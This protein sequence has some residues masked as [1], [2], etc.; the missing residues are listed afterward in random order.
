M[1]RMTTL[2][3][4]ATVT[5]CAAEAAFS[6]SPVG[7]GPRLSIVLDGGSPFSLS[8]PVRN[9]VLA[10][11]GSD[12]GLTCRVTGVAAAARYQA[13]R[14]NWYV[15]EGLRGG[16]GGDRVAQKRG[17][18]SF[19]LVLGGL[20]PEDSGTLKCTAEPERPYHSERDEDNAPEPPLE[21]TITLKVKCKEGASHHGTIIIILRWLCCSRSL[22]LFGNV[23][24]WRS[25]P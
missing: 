5:L 9:F 16:G 22:W 11:E 18:N 10:E 12:L 8:K 2:V 13:Y 25:P 14:L 15:T 20:R 19:G 24:F 1:S 6:S 21:Q 17:R 7:A 3:L 4:L 23:S